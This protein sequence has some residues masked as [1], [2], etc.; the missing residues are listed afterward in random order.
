VPGSRANLDHLVI[1]RT[2]VWLIDSKTTRARVR[3]GWRSVHLGGR[4]LDTGPTRWEAEVVADRLGTEV[5]ALIVLHA[6]GLRRR[7]I[8]CGGVRVVPP[9]GLVR[10]LRRGWR[11]LP[12][13]QVAELAARADAVFSPAA[14]LLGKRPRSDG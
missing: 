4:R 2:G 12:A 11:R 3:A 14:N 8:R 13:G 1:G 5:R 10:R 9:H 6:A 7:G